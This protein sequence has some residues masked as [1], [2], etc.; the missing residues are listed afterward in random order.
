MVSYKDAVLIDEPC[1]PK[2]SV[3][4]PMTYD[5]LLVF[6]TPTKTLRTRSY[7]E[8][9]SETIYEMMSFMSDVKRELSEKGVM[10]EFSY[11]DVAE[12]CSACLRIEPVQSDL[13]DDD[14]ENDIEEY[15]AL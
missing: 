1:A 15:P 3:I 9:M 5:E 11:K 14:S 7:N 10:N 2:E 8:V 4:K 6:L 12:I 13:S